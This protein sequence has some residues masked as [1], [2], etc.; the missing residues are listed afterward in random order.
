M[1]NRQNCFCVVC[2]IAA[3]AIALLASGYAPVQAQDKPVSF[4][5]DV[6]PIV[7]EYCMACH[8]PKKKNGKYDMSTPHLLMEGGVNGEMIIPGDIEDSEFYTLIVTD[9]ERRMPPRDKG[10]AVPKEQAEIIKKW[11]EQGA[12][13][14]KGLDMKTDIVKELRNRWQPPTPPE[15]YN[16]PAV[17]NAIAF[18][19]DGKTLVTGG[20]HELNVWSVPEGKLTKR[21][22]TRAER[23]YG[24]EFLDDQRIAVA[25]GRPGQEGDVR[26]Y[27][28]NAQG[29]SENGV[30]LLDGV[31]DSKVM[32]A[33]LLDSDDSVLCLTLSPDGKKLAA[34]GCDRTIRLWDISGGPG[35]AKLEQTIEN[36]A[37]WVLGVA[38]SKD[39]N[40]LVSAGR[41]KTAK[42]WDLKAKESVMT[43]PG[44]QNIVYGVAISQNGETGFSVG[45]DRQIRTWKPGGD[46]KQLKAAGGHGDEVLKIALHPKNPIFATGSADKTVRLWDADKVAATKTLE[47][48]KDHVFALTF[49]ADGKMVAAGTY[50]GEVRIW[51][52]EDGK[53]LANFNA[54]PGFAGAAV[55]Q[56]K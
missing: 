5:N 35:K 15:K 54:S 21:L 17:I 20:H 22:H 42:V 6:A 24:I 1:S 37:D 2:A 7:K 43:F 41:D 12:K 44:H 48:F 28:L 56:G 39:G 3:V 23:A 27:D 45:A 46:G 32:V 55:S 25:G 11:I 4:I 10:E 18:S 52:T 51:N 36:H 40:Y 29:Q 50:D 19:P 30:T 34:G 49:S 38:I 9:E 53:E 8:D 33:Q 47:G 13:F 14:D 26:I 16:Y 31:K